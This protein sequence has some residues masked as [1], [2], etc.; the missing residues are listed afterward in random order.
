MKEVDVLVVVDTEGALSSGDLQNNVYLI[1]T[2]KYMGSWGEGSC[3]L[4]TN[5]MDGE[6]VKW[7]VTSVDPGNDVNIV[8]FTGQIIDQ[9]ICTPSQQGIEDDIFW[10]GRVETRGSTSS[11]QYSI[12]L[13]MEGK[14][15]SFDPFLNVKK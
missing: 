14:K 4:T 9:S 5:C 3:E 11:Y 15:M 8:G 1:D 7:R 6:I 10:E 13:Q 2:N 12:V